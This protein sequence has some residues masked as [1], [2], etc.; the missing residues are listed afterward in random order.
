MG[1]YRKISNVVEAFRMT[2]GRRW[3][4][5]EWPNWLNL[6]WQKE[7]GT[8]SLWCSE[9]SQGEQLV[10][11]TAEGVCEVTFGDWIIRGANGALDLCDADVFRAN[12]ESVEE[13]SDSNG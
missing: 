10:L 4:N 7:P 8:G 1:R 2:K 13:E 5:S 11:G 12:Y 6:A 9:S 3:D